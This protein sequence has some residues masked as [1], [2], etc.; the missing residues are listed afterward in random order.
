[1]LES[2]CERM[3][4]AGSDLHPSRGH[5][6]RSSTRGQS[7][8]FSVERTNAPFPKKETQSEHS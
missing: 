5:T 8:A 1:M 7:T 2:D 4:M 6:S 3:L